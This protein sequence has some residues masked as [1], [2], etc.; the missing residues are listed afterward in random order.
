MAG[1]NALEMVRIVEAMIRE[2]QL[3]TSCV[4][5]IQPF[6]VSSIQ[7][8]VSV[9]VLVEAD[10]GLRQSNNEFIENPWGFP[11]VPVAQTRGYTP[12]ESLRLAPRNISYEWFGHP[13][14]W[15]DPALTAWRESETLDP[16]RWAVRMFYT[17]VAL[18][19]MVEDGQGRYTWVN[20]IRARGI[21]YSEE[22]WHEYSRG[23][24]TPQVD[25]VRWGLDDLTRM[26]S[27]VQRIEEA[28]QSALR[29]IAEIQREKVSEFHMLRQA[30]VT[31][32]TKILSR[33]GEAEGEVEEAVRMARGISEDAR[34]YARN[35]AGANISYADLAKRATS[36]MERVNDLTARMNSDAL[37]IS[38]PTISETVASR[39]QFAL[40]ATSMQNYEAVR[41][42][43]RDSALEVERDRLI[44]LNNQSSD[45][46]FFQFYQVARAEVSSAW[47]KL[48]LAY[49]NY[50]REK[51]GLPPFSSVFEFR[52][53]TAAER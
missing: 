26:G 44:K 29:R 6:R 43:G 18:G 31:E 11:F 9:R 27:S 20:A 23:Y 30:C 4:G 42:S 5:R 47:D 21:Q 15:I 2:A 22:T 50:D 7:E 33:N 12:G 19:L 28:T 1:E 36:V 14:F 16:T 24:E 53:A 52:A 10:S 35:S 41:R 45:E 46:E 34:L 37:I 3:D 17:M 48:T 39:I 13:I 49:V 38:A 25:S 32:A 8:M 40:I 51:R